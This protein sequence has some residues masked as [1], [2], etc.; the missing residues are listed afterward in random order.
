MS[1][2]GLIVA[3]GCSTTATGIAE[4]YGVLENLEL[5]RIIESGK[6]EEM[7]RQGQADVRHREVSSG[8]REVLVTEYLLFDEVYRIE[9]RE[10]IN[11]IEGIA[12]VDVQLAEVKQGDWED[13]MRLFKLAGVLKCLRNDS[14]QARPRVAYRA[15][16]GSDGKVHGIRVTEG[17]VP[18]WTLSEDDLNL[19][20]R[21]SLQ[22]ITT[23]WFRQVAR[24]SEGSAMPTSSRWIM[25]S[26]GPRNPNDPLNLGQQK[27]INRELE[28]LIR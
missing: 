28:A 9:V 19:Y 2:V 15:W 12:N 16:K 5:V 3:T 25:E 7:T 24:P 20:I 8:G 23:M 1:L 14:Y 27:F 4:S 6:A 17:N 10:A 26:P 13:T 18:Q 11:P 22:P 21:T